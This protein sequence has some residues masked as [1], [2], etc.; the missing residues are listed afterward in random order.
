[1]IS[2]PR[3]TWML[4][5]GRFPLH[6]SRQWSDIP[7]RSAGCREIPF[8]HPRI[9]ACLRLPGAFRSLP[10]PSSA[11]KPSYPPAGVFWPKASAVQFAWTA[12]LGHSGGWERR[13]E[14]VRPKPPSVHPRPIKPVFY[15]SP[16]RRYRPVAEPLPGEWLPVFGSGFGL[17]CFQPLSAGA[18]LPGT[19][20]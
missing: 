16:R 9:N 5:F 18:Q 15:G 3:P 7:R 8:G 14:D 19:A 4:P 1:M 2:F 6:S 13:A 11:P 17:R 12:S 10:R 20:L